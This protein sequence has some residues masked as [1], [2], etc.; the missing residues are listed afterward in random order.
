[1]AEAVSPMQKR[2]LSQDH[3]ESDIKKFKADSPGPVISVDHLQNKLSEVISQLNEDREND[4][5]VV[6]GL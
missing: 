3:S 2:E 4:Q 1:M 6:D 5:V